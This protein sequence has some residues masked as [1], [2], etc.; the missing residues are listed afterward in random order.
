MLWFASRTAPSAVAAALGRQEFSSK[1]Q[2]LAKS[3]SFNI[4]DSPSIRVLRGRESIPVSLRDCL[5]ASPGFA[6]LAP[7][8]PGQGVSFLR[9]LLLPIVLAAIGPPDSGRAWAQ[10]FA[11]GDFTEKQKSQINEYLDTHHDRFDLFHATHPFGQVPGLHTANNETKPVGILIAGIAA[12]AS[13]PLFSAYTDADELELT[14]ADALA[15]MLYTQCWDTAGIK[16]GAVGDEKAKNNKSYGNRTGP[17]GAL[18]VV[19]PTG[20]TVF[21][22]LWLNTPIVPAGLDPRARPPRWLCEP[23]AVWEERHAHGL[24]DL[25]TWQCRRIRLLP[26]DTKH[27]VRVNQAIITSGDRMIETPQ[28]EPHTLWRTPPKSEDGPAVPR[29]YRHTAGKAA[30]RGLASLLALDRPSEG[31][32]VLASFLLSQI[33]DLRAEEYLP[34]DYPLRVEI[35][36]VVYGTQSSVVEDTIS[37]AIPMPVAALGTDIALR[38]A[39]LEVAGQADRLESAVNVLD[40]DLRRAAGGDPVPWDKGQRPGEFLV[41]ALD[42]PARTLLESLR[43][44]GGDDERLETALTLWERIARDNAFAIG[45]QLLTRSDPSVFVGRTVGGRIYRQANAEFSF[46]R[47]VKEILPRAAAVS[48]DEKGE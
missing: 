14:P 32:G 21:E 28:D 45:E 34:D 7:D 36:G 20:R 22:T 48:F 16:S 1:R 24:L 5:T 40:A 44:V 47:A 41:H 37:D 2:A 29:P 46:R 18:G 35:H 25:L 19:V 31:K 17:L 13:V 4:I 8:H 43:G 12:G 11:N 26:A 3:A 38:D 10:T 6:A 15:W 9:Q 23:G 42:A 30:W 33:H 39:L 27:G